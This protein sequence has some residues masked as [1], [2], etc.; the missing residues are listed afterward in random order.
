MAVKHRTL[1][2]LGSISLYKRRGNRSIRL[3]VSASGEIRVSLPPWL[4]YAAAER[5]VLS[6]RGWIEDRLA[7]SPKA[8]LRHGQRIGKAHRLIFEPSTSALRVSL[9]QNE[10]RIIHPYESTHLNVEVQAAARRGSIRALRTEAEQ[11]LPSRLQD[12]SLQTGLNFNSVVIKNLKS[13]WGS[14]SSNGDITLNLFLMQLPW[15][16]IDY[17]LIHELTHTKV[18]RHGPPFWRELSKHVSGA[19]ELKTE[20]ASYHPSL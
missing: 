3:S 4:P 17:V 12:L 11:L 5:F 18:M 1:P 7:A 2:G 6:K 8:D 16:L 19:K 14:C 15:H 9:R 20:I 13:R 10:V